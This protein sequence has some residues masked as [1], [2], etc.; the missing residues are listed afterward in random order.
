MT[1]ETKTCQNCKQDFTVEPA[2]FD[3][4]KKID[5]PTPTWC[6]LC[7]FKRRNIWRNE[8]VLFRRP[9]SLT[10]KEIFSGIPPQVKAKVY[11]IDYWRSDNWDPMDYGREYDFSRP[12]FEQFRELHNATPWPSRVILDLVNSDYSD[13]A[14][15]LKNSYLCFNADYIE[16]S[17]YVV[18]AAYVKDSLDMLDGSRAE[19][20]C[21]STL[22]LDLFKTHFSSNCIE[23]SEVWCSKDLVGCMS[24]VGCVGLRKK[25]YYIFN[26]PYSKEEYAEKVKELRLNT[27][28]GLQGVLRK[29]REIAMTRPVRFMRGIQNVGS[30]GDNMAHTKNCKEC[31]G[32]NVGQDLKYCQIV[33]RKVEDCYDY[34]VWGD[35]ASRI[36]EC[37]TCGIEVNDLKFCFDCWP[38][39]NALTYSMRCRS[40]S[41]LF[42]CMSLKKKEYCI[43]NKQYSKEG[44]EAMIKK[45]RAHMDAMPYVDTRGLVYKYGEFFP[46]EFSPFSYNETILQDL[47]PLTEKIATEQGF[48]WREQ[49]SKEFAPTVQAAAL[50]DDIDN[51]TDN[52]LKE[53]IACVDCGKAYRIIRMEFDILKKLRIPLPRSC[54]QC[55][56]MAQ[57][58]LIEP[59]VFYDRQCSKCQAPFRTSIKPERPEL[60]YCEKCYQDLAT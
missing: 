1:P 29:M 22:F 12:F 8:R 50:P 17:A 19:L 6:P 56:Y 55:R 52:V 44:Y 46:P 60:V 11:D 24:C 41:N 14:S 30:T 51:I 7:R 35:S 9:D 43:L 38:S 4:Y 10:G 27:Y 48:F 18:R 28:S 39:S 42:G 20:S 54:Q 31:W 58:K 21:G 37:M 2:D 49:P 16:N 32:V 40:S 36:Y 26:Q 5:V 59:P 3:F 25:S 15:F 53:I 13:Q 47:F 45:I 23:C 34:T 57:A 33:T